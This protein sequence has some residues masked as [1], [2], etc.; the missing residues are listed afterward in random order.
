MDYKAARLRLDNVKDAQ[1]DD[2]GGEVGE[3]S[4]YLSV[5][6]TEDLGRDV[7]EKGAFTKTIK[8]RESVPLLWQHWPDEPIGK[9]VDLSEDEKGLKVRGLINLAVKRGREAHAL[10]KQGALTGMSIGYDAVK[11]SD[12]KEAK[13]RRLQEI[14]LWEGSVVTFPMNQA[15][16][17]DMVKARQRY[18]DTTEV[19]EEI[20]ALREELGE[21]TSAPVDEYDIDAVVGELVEDVKAGRTLSAQNVARIRSIA[22]AQR[23]IADACEQL[24]SAVEP[25]GEST[26]E[27][28]K[29]G[30]GKGYDPDLFQSF[31]ED[32]SRD[33]QAIGKERGD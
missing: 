2:K 11:A 21:K 32:F 12:D 25:D 5:F 3:F 23:Q 28:P 24:L 33:V 18:T 17:V 27:K 15:A 13:T 31:F 20:K 22:E 29:E 14:K 4:G 10:L 1:K 26:P 6:D 8:E 30:D 9:L 7:V 16:L 19:M